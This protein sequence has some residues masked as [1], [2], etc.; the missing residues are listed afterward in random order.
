M[1]DAQYG[2]DESAPSPNSTTSIESEEADED[3]ARRILAAKRE[4]KK[5]HKCSICGRA[6]LRYSISNR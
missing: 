4:A 3:F 1:H 2:N 6:F 5:K